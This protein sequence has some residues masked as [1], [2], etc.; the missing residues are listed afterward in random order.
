MV[1][2]ELSLYCNSEKQ[3]L[4]RFHKSQKL[5]ISDINTHDVST[6]KFQS[7]RFLGVIID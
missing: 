5:L 1:E 2:L 7:V 4:I 6:T 3:N